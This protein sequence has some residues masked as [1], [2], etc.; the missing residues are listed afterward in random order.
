V[1]YRPVVKEEIG[2]YPNVS[3][4]NLPKPCM[5][6]DNP[7]C[8]P[9]CPVGATF[10]R[11][12]GLVEIDYDQCIGCRYCITA[13]PY[14][15]RMFDFGEYYTQD[16]PHLAEYDKKATFDWQKE[17][18]RSGLKSPVGN[19]RKCTFCVHRLEAGA[20]PACVTTCIGGANYFG[21]IS[22]PDSLIS[23]KIGNE[24]VMRLKEEAGTSPKV[25]YI[26]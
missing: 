26:I 2:T 11:P 12:D 21:D 6:C 19:A 17:R 24:K 15:H 3:I 13:C 7:P 23:Q 9:V 20:L 16:A 18:K 1:V 5:Q 14:E 4:R 22:D 8:V 25:F 10:V